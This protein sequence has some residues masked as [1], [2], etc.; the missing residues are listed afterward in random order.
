MIIKPT[1]NIPQGRFLAMPQRFRMFCAGFGS[2]KTWVGC[3]AICKHFW[4]F[5]LV[6]Q[7]YF[8]P[9]YA[10]IRDIL[11]PTIEEV[12]FA[13]GQNVEIKIGAH[14]IDVY[15]GRQYRGTIICRSMDK[16]QNIIGFKI[17]HALI[18]E[19]DVLPSDKAEDAWQKI[20]ARMRYNVPGIKNGIDVASTPEGFRFCH[21]KFVQL[22]Q[23]DA[24]LTTNY[25]L[26]QASTYENEKYLPPGYIPGL[27]ESYPAEL[28][29]AYINGQF[30]NLTSGT[31]YNCYDRTR[32]NS[33]ETIAPGEPL[34]IGMDF[35]VGKMAATVYVQRRNG[36]HAVAEL[37]DIFDTP[38]MVRAII[39]RW[40][41][42]EDKQRR[43]VVYPDVSGGSRHTTDAS[44]SDIAILQQSGLQIRASSTN[45]AVRDRV[46][47]VNKQF[48]IGRLW[49]NAQAC[50]TIARCFEQ[51]AYDAN[52]DPDKSTGF[53]HQNDASG[54]VIAYERPI[55]RPMSRMKITGV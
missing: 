4:E 48:E 30:T 19:F 10:H 21:K 18:D 49:V 25:G 33:P 23:E 26:T 6:N 15:S 22:P 42:G 13:F 3:M 34:F 54:Y 7:G 39:E 17:G 40:R 29:K 36:Y 43:I 47:A 14:E 50:P 46:L 5:P 38:A 53:D 45:P 52:G 12:A 20:L 16:P 55:I 9:T 28:I 32:C 51:Q 1:A 2:G 37:H 44:K 35:N 11:Y 8:A 24:A 31:V 41:T 27:L